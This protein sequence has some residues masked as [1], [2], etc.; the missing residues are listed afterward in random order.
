MEWLDHQD[1]S[2]YEKRLTVDRSVVLSYAPRL[3]MFGPIFWLSD[4]LRVN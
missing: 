3:N 1:A 4:R 2:H